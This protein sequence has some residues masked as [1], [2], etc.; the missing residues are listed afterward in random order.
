MATESRTALALRVLG[1]TALFV[2]GAIHLQEYREL[3]ST[4]PTIGPLFLLSFAGATVSAVLLLMPL[5]RLLP[6]RWGGLAT[7]A[8][9]V[10]GIGQATS[11]FVFLA[12]SEQRPLFGFQEPGYDPSAILS[13]RIAEVAT[14]ALLGGYLVARAARRGTRTPD[15]HVH[16]EYTSAR[17]GS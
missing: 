12:I 14:V 10:A 8:L 6:G 1:A 16:A 11:Q 4:I 13:V 2:V 7:V 5:G 15:R 3:Y 9:A 17:R